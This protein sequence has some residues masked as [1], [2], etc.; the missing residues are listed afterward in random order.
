MSKCLILRI[1][2]EKALFKVGKGRIQKRIVMHTLHC[3]HIECF[4]G[5]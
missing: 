3:E 1:V 2:D 5:I 4:H